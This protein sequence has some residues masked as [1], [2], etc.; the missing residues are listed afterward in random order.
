MELNR[1]SRDARQRVVLVRA[2]SRLGWP[3]FRGS[4]VSSWS[5]MAILPNLSRGKVIEGDVV[6]FVCSQDSRIQAICKAL[7]KFAELLSRFTNAFDV[8]LDPVVLIARDDVLPSLTA[9]ALLSFRDLVAISIIPYSRSLNTVYRTTNR[10]VYANS[11]WIYPW[12]LGKNTQSLT[13]STPAFSGI[14][15]VEAFHGQASP[16]LPVMQIDDIDTPLLEALLACWKRHYLGTRRRWKDR[17]IFRSLN[18][19]V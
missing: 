18:M 19:A 3:V 13:T 8:A 5:P 7:P 2:R 4:K 1:R 14:H 17:A 16:E 9:D 6:A 11:F 10:I 15:V 12:M